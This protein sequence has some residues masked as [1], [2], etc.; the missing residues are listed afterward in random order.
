ML[1]I[2]AIM[3]LILGIHYIESH[4]KSRPIVEPLQNPMIA[5][6][7][8]Y[9]A[10]AGIVE[11][12]TEVIG[13][14]PNIAGIVANVHVAEG[15]VV[16][17][18][19]LLLT[20]DKRQILAN[21][22]V[23]EAQVLKAQAD[24]I[25]DQAALKDAQQKLDR[26]KNII[27]QRAIVLQDLETAQLNVAQAQAKALSAEKLLLSAHAQ[28]DSIK[29]TL[30]LYEVRAPKNGTVMEVNVRTGEY[31]NFA[32]PNQTPAIR[33]GNLNPLHVRVDIDE[34]D[35]WR[36]KKNTPA[37]ANL[38]GNP[39]MKTNLKF[40]RMRPYVIPKKN[41]TNDTT[42]R[43]DTRVMQVIYSFNSEKLP[44]QPGQLMDVYIRSLPIR[45]KAPTK[46]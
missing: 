23:N 45:E 22:Q 42:E 36:F 29:T 19:Q 21:K 18:G 40:V 9:I 34:R 12:N 2:I 32:H 17:K 25:H 27:D 11:P 30:D 37:I 44:V 46:D 13:L 1:P 41:L 35:V 43:V 6:F 8:D 31:A 7:P 26:L 14:S 38:Q 28:L 15:D 33:F 39:E 4:R 16:K 5:P 20:L 3:G 10:G 24:L